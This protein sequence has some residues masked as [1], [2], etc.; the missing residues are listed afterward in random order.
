M[1]ART[2]ARK[3]APRKLTTEAHGRA[4][5]VAML[6]TLSAY[7]LN[8]VGGCQWSIEAQYRDEGTPQDNV[9]LQYLRRCTNSQALEGFCAVLTDY[10][11][12]SLDGGAPDASVYERLTEYDVNGQPG[13]WPRP[14][15]SELPEQ[16]AFEAFMALAVPGYRPRGECSV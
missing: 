3:A 8:K 4:L 6:R 11:A 7:P 12:C 1:A 9:A 16:A 5:A 14:E 2:T 15:D 10:I 13:R